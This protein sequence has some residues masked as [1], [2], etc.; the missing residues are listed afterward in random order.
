MP[1][2][3]HKLRRSSLRLSS[4]WA[5]LGATL[6]PLP[7]LACII[8]VMLEVVRADFLAV[9]SVVQIFASQWLLVLI[10]SLLLLLILILTWMGALLG[11]Y[12]GLLVENMR[13]HRADK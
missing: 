13:Q 11:Y 1:Y 3:E 8:L 6:L 12:G 2:A 4:I 7:S 5:L 9:V 10:I